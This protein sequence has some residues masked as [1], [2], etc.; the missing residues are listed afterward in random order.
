MRQWLVRRL[1]PW[2]G[3]LF[4]LYVTWVLVL[5][6]A[7]LPESAGQLP[8][9][10]D[11]VVHWGLFAGFA[12]L[13]YWNVRAAWARAVIVIGVSAAFAGVIEFVQGPLEFR[14]GDA[15]DFGWGAFGAVVGYWVA[16]LVIDGSRIPPAS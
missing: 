5:T 1:A 4:A 6:L 11:K 9:W 13:L 7:P 10:F 14:S 12:A 2:R 15:W 16:R 3:V 8:D